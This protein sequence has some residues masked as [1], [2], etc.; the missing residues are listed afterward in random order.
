M[1]LAVAFGAQALGGNALLKWG[2]LLGSA[3]GM[4]LLGNKQSN[5]NR[6]ND[7]KIS[8]S[9]YGTGL[10]IVYGTMRCT[11]N[12]IWATDL[13]ERKK[14][15]NSKG[16]DITGKKK[17]SKKGNKVYEYYGNFAMA[18]CEGTVE[19]LIRVWADSNLIFDK[20]A[21]ARDH[22][23]PYYQKVV[24]PG[25]SQQSG[26]GGGKT[27]KTGGKMKGHQGDSG[28]FNFRFYPGTE[29]QLQDSFMVEKEGAD[30]VPA[31]RGTCYLMFEDMWLQDFG[32]R[33]PTITAE[34]AVRK[35]RKVTYQYARPLIESTVIPP[36][37]NVL[38][39][40]P[41][42]NRYRFYVI[43]HGPG[44]GPLVRTYDLSSMKEIRRAELTG[45]VDNIP[46]FNGLGHFTG[47]TTI[48][49]AVTDV[50]GISPEGDLVLV[51]QGGNSAPIIFVDPNSLAPLSVF[52]AYSA[53]LGND[54]DSVQH[55]ILATPLMYMAVDTLSGESTPGFLTGVLSEFG[56]LAFFSHPEGVLQYTFQRIDGQMGNGINLVPGLPDIDSST[57]YAIGNNHILFRGSTTGQPLVGFDHGQ[58][59]TLVEIWRHVADPSEIGYAVTSPF[60]VIGAE[61]VAFFETVEANDP[62]VA[63]TWAVKLDPIT[64]AVQWRTKVDPRTNILWTG[65]VKNAPIVTGNKMMWVGTQGSASRTVWEVDFVAQT[66]NSY[67]L[68]IDAS[69]PDQFQVY[70]S[71]GGYILQGGTIVD[72]DNPDFNGKWSLF[73]SKVDRFVQVPVGIDEIFN[74]LIDRVGIPRE[75]ANVDLLNDD[76]INGY[77]VEN[78]TSARQIIEDLTKVFMFDVVES[79]Y[80]LKGVSRGRLAPAIT[81]HEDD[82]GDVGSQD[83][84]V[85][86]KETTTQAIDLPMTCNVSYV[87]PNKNYETG[88][89]HYKRP[90][91]PMPVMHS[92]DKLEINMPMSMLPDFAKQ[93]AYKVLYS[94]WAE[95]T[96]YELLFSWEM[97]AY[98]PTDVAIFVMNDGFTF[99]ARLLKMDLGVDFSIQAQAV[100]QF[101]GSYDSSILAVQPGG[102]IHID[103]HPAPTTF[104]VI[105]DVPYLADTDAISSAGSFEYYWGAGAYTE[106]LKYAAMERRLPPAQFVAE[107][108]TAYEA[109]YGNVQ[110]TVPVPYN[111]AYAEDDI[112]VLTLVP[113]HTFAFNDQPFDLETIPDDEWPSEDNMLIV[114]GEVIL[115]KTVEELDDGRFLV[116]RLIRGARGTENAAYQHTGK[117]NERYIIVTDL[118]TRPVKESIDLAGKVFQ[119]KTESPGLLINL[120]N[121]I[122]KQLTAASLKPYAPNDFNRLENTPTSGDIRVT[123]QRRTR[124]GGGWKDSVG[125]VPLNEETEKYDAYLLTAPFDETTF[126]PANPAT[127]KREF[128]NL[129][130]SQFDYTAAMQSADSFSDADPLYVVVFQMSATIGRGFPGSDTL[131]HL[132]F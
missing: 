50:I 126:D 47:F 121:T 32:N 80:I 116:S 110:G 41:D 97:L 17:A 113:G 124:F 119:F 101:P 127:F 39:A 59:T 54:D 79:D 129:T 1:Q 65:P 100:A 29:V 128:A 107:D 81:V 48:D 132:L 120:D 42:P 37:N 131:Y 13:V 123:W 122:S 43:G 106:G 75:H 71:M 89:Q 62:A 108:A 9:T 69:I 22:K 15:F 91:S 26:D 112:T 31:Y 57:F 44:G 35:E 6:L 68:P 28:R 53:D 63:G 27:G 20:Y 125:T 74:D 18:L 94:V 60:V 102:T 10:A 52:G 36:N 23:D 72:P 12:M 55:A 104:P 64:G 30:M 5:S 51:G 24:G 84:T 83:Q 73:L 98:D 4:Y 14:Y 77:I 99:Q 115:F 16:K 92:R 21:G 78:P 61:C 33:I 46:T 95:R 105:L 130:T 117:Y 67:I 7:L 109:V 103:K 49:L 19:E 96:D 58:E 85:S 82:L 114:G 86:Y 34:V 70:W 8:S 111:G 2:L 118:G 45:T 25:F 90:L 66:I 88:T 40:F 76:E 3:V 87:N 56:D 11:G 38:N 93:L